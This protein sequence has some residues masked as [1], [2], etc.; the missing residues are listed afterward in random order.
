MYNNNNNNSNNNNNNNNKDAQ[1][2]NPL[3]HCTG[4]IK[5][6]NIKHFVYRWQMNITA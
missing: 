2:Y 6:N 5:R 3:L 4:P 1:K